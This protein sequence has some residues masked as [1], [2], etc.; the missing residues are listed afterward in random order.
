MRVRPFFWFMLV[1]VC[2]GVLTFAANM[3]VAR[4]VPL[5]A[6]IEQVSTSNSSSAEVRLRLTDTEGMPVDQARVT[7]QASMPD[8]VMAPQTANVQA[9]G[10]G[11]YLASINFSMAGAWK[12]DITAHADGFAATNQSIVI[13][14]V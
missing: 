13:D 3:P 9:L 10:Q 11:L 7:P 6:H 1:A 2:L 12:I 14:V 8:M 5:M 4:V